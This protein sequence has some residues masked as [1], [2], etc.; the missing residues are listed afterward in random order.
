MV[1]LDLGYSPN[2]LA[3]FSS[4]FPIL[5]FDILPSDDIYESMFKISETSDE[6]MTDM[7][8]EVG[9]GSK[10]VFGNLGSLLIFQV[11]YWLFIAANTLFLKYF[12]KDSIPNRL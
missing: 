6:P 8:D 7:F 5:T 3:Y 4:I 10:L 2:L 9:Y 1:V 12:P 11:L